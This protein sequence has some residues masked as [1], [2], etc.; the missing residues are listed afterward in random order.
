MYYRLYNLT[1]KDILEQLCF[2]IEHMIVANIM[3]NRFVPNNQLFNNNTNNTNNT[4]NRRDTYL[5]VGGSKFNHNCDPNCNYTLIDDKLIVTSVK[6]ILEG[7]EFTIAYNHIT[8]FIRIDIGEMTCGTFTIYINMGSYAIDVISILNCINVLHAGKL[9]T[10][11]GYVSRS[12]GFY[13]KSY[14]TIMREIS[15]VSKY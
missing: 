7:E 4:N 5:Y 1:N 11:V 15:L 13:I 14:V 9:I 8:H 2:Q 10:V 3:T 12:I 6:D